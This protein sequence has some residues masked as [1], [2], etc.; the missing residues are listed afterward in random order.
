ML[1]LDDP[2]VFGKLDP[3]DMLGR[4]GD[5]PQQCLEAWH[6]A[7]EFTLPSDYRQ[8]NKVV[9]SGMGGSAV[10]GGLLAGLTAEEGVPIFVHRDYGLPSF[11]DA[12]TLFITSSYSG[13]TEETLSSFDLALRTPAKKLVL[14]TGG[15]LKA[16]AQERGIPTFTIDYQA[17]P[18]AA[19]AHSFIPLIGILH[20]LEL[21][22]DKSQDIAEMVQVLTE[23]KS[24]VNAVCPLTHNPAKQLATKLFGRIAIV[25]GAGILSEVA[26]RWKTQINENSKCWAFYELFPELNHNAIVGYE[27]PSEMADRVFVLLLRSSKLA[28]RTLLRYEVTCDILEQ[29]NIG[30]EV[31]EGSGQSALSQMMSL[32]LLGDYVSY[33]LALLNEADPTPVKAIDYLKQRLGRV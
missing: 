8:V 23:L 31:I 16:I 9:I 13:M 32:V 24:T 18:R 15:E 26:R 10:G 28:P 17:Q 25:Y 27:Y 22:S 20:K 4:I 19:L 21:I 2:Q 14:T 5:L 33:Y 3:G 12:S 7:L 30:Y 1:D 6:K 11:V 29:R